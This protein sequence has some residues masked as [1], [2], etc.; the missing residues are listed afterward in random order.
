M[1]WYYGTYSCGHEGRVN[2]IGPVKDRQWKADRHFSGL[3]PECYKIHVE[4]EKKKATEEAAKKANE[5]ELPELQ[6]TTKQVEW[7]QVL[8]QKLIDAF[9]EID[10]KRYERWRRFYDMKAEFEELPIILSYILQTY[11]SAKYFIDRRDYA[12]T[13]IINDEAPKALKTDQEK[14]QEKIEAELAAQVQEE[15]TVYPENSISNVA[16]QID[17]TE[18]LVSV[19]YEKNEKFREIVRELRYSWNGTAW[20]RKIT[21]TTGSSVDRAAELGN[22]LLNAGFP[23]TILDNET[24]E[25]AINGMFEPE[26]TRW[27]MYRNKGD[28][29]GWLAIWWDKKK[30]DLYHVA[31]SLPG[32]KWDK[33]SIVVR[34]E[35]YKEIEEFAELYGFK[36]SEQARKTIEDIKNKI[37]NASKIIPAD[38]PEVDYKDGLKEILNSGSDIIDDLKD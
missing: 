36:F 21:Q 11:T 33:P 15:S 10:Q 30:E 9:G 2:I 20:E 19:R 13:Q 16:A 23:V 12:I 4:A 28:Y 7:A 26:C 5:M 24:R 3:C 18:N 38:V 6:G 1:A 22:K 35:H 31:R 29:E 34:P 25:K 8:R 27:I 32:A 17:F 14:M 37:I